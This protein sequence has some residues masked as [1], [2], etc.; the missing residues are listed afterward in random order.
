MSEFTPI[1]KNLDPS[2]KFSIKK[3][4]MPLAKTKSYVRMHLLLKKLNNKKTFKNPS[5]YWVKDYDLYMVY[6]ESQVIVSPKMTS[7]V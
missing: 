7:A 6:H 5:F 4:E 2:I 3:N 1:F